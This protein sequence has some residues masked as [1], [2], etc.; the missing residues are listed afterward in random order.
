MKKPLIL[1]TACL[2]LVISIF[3]FARTTSPKKAVESSAAPA[4][5]V[6]DIDNEMR[7]L[8]AKLS[9]DQLTRVTLL[10]EETGKGHQ[11][12]V[13]VTAFEELAN[14]WKDSAKAFAPYAFYTSQ[15]AKLDNSEK[16]LTFAARLFSGNLRGIENEA[17]LAW[18]T[19][20]AIDLYKRAIAL[21]T[22]NDDLRIGLGS[23][24]IYGKGRSGNSQETMEGVL[25][26]LKVVRKDSTNMKAQMLLGVGGIISGQF[27]NAEKRLR[28]VVANQPENAEAV[29]YLADALAGAGKKE[30][31][32][33]Y[34]EL[35]KKLIN[36]P[37][38]NEEAD[39][40]IR[41]LR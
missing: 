20:E 30:Q 4:S 33:R 29:S 5:P 32:I 8:K 11:G 34:Y 15:A 41:S 9:P 17:E 39:A 14:F 24:Y 2:L 19:T 22:A 16:K 38:Y 25:E 36:N 21:D 40:R 1:A 23:C 28:K 12:P 35:S 13:Q 7:G 3:I 6:F 26:L 27:D 18:Q 37:H 31:A 10:E